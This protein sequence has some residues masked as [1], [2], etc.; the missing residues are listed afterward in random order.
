MADLQYIERGFVLTRHY[1]IQG[2]TLHLETSGFML[3]QKVVLDIPL[4]QMLP[5]PTTF[6]VHNAIKLKGV[7]VAIL[8]ASLTAFVAYQN[9]KNLTPY[10]DEGFLLTFVGWLCVAMGIGAIISLVV[11]IKAQGTITSASFGAEGGVIGF[12]LSKKG[13]HADEYETFVEQLIIA[14]KRARSE[15]S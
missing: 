5:D 6:T 1:T 9:R 4:T 10:V 8:L 15:D 7:G 3:G 13:P 12:D 14:I 11:G 2:G